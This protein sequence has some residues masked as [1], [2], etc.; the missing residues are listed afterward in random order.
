[1]SIS[2]NITASKN[3]GEYN[4]YN[5]MSGHKDYNVSVTRYT[6]KLVTSNY[7]IAKHYHYYKKNNLIDLICGKDLQ[8]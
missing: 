5:G 8:P 7:H 3:W 1:M 4:G 2:K 6:H